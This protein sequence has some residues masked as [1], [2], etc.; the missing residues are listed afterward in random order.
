MAV[1]KS[2]AI[3]IAAKKI[4]IAVEQYY[5]F[6]NEGFKWCY[7]CRTW[8]LRENYGRDKL[9]GDGLS[10]RCFRC[11]RVVIKISRKGIPSPLKGIPMSVESKAKM[12]KAHKGKNNHRWKGGISFRKT[13]RDP[14]KTKAKRAVNHA[15]ES[16]RLANVKLLPCFDCGKNAQEYHHYRGY[17]NPH[18]LDVQA[19][20]AKCHRRRHMLS[21]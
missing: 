10:G 13:Q 15:V 21:Y 19:L 8:Q 9:K 18:W 3:K 14:L 16:G 2:G 12:S 1:T 6:I 5:N 17:K 20:C 11:C 4:G 7:A